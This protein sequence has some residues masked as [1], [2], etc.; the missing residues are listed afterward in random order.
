M[1]ALLA[2]IEVLH[3][4]PVLVVQIRALP[5]VE[6]V[7]TAR[8]VG[9]ALPDVALPA[10]VLVAIA[11]MP[12]TGNPVAFVSV[13]DDGVPNAPPDCTAPVMRL[14]LPCA[15]VPLVVP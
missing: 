14:S 2:V 11:A 4:N 5:A 6:H 3:P 1:D 12:P 10:T 8:A 13:P 9:D 7:P 15:A